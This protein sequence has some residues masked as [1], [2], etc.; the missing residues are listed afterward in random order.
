VPSPK[1][2]NRNIK[3]GE[4]IM[5]EMNVT[6]AGLPAPR[7]DI[8]SEF[9]WQ[10]LANRELLLQCCAHCRKVRFPA[11]PA[12]CYCGRDGHALVRASG[13]GEL[14]SW[15]V[16]H[17]AFNPALAGAVPYAVG[18]IELQ[19]GCRMVARLADHR[20]LRPGIPCQVYYVEHPD[21]VEA[22]FRRS[23]C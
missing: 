19:E 22:R 9:Y 15:V 2:A 4:P 6:E 3:A 16:V 20:Q 5:A 7:R 23:D 21:W 11:M 12:C 1:N 10:G 17:H 18:V 13:R 8:E 14:Y